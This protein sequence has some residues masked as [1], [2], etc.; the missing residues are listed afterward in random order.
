MDSARDGQRRPGLAEAADLLRGALRMRL[1]PG[2]SRPPRTVLS[3]VKIMYAGAVLNLATWLTVMATIGSVKTA[4]ARAAPAQW[5]AFLVHIVAVEVFG[6][7]AIGLWLWLA[8]ANGR[9]H[10]WARMVF[11]AFFALTTSSLLLWLGQGGAVYAPA[12]LMAAGVL[13]LAE[14]AVMVLIFSKRSNPHYRHEPARR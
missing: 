4:V 11:L 3:A 12:D 8:W 1:G 13:W 10:D 7:L 2:G 14:L 9:G 5:H 6:P